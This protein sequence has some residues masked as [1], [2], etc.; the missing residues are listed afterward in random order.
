MNEENKREINKILNM[1]NYTNTHF[2]GEIKFATPYFR[3]I[4]FC[5]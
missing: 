3:K 5:F 2:F 1:V 4:T